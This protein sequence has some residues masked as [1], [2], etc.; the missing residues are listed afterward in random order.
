MGMAAQEV[1]C[2][3]LPDNTGSLLDAEYRAEVSTVLCGAVTSRARAEPP[4]LYAQIL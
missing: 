3:A 2:E 4:G 1:K